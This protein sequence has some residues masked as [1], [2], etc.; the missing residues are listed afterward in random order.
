MASAEREPITGVWRR[1]DPPPLPPCKN[2]SDLYQFQERPLANVGGHVHPSPPRGDATGYVQLSFVHSTRTELDWT[3][4]RQLP[5]RIV[6]RYNWHSAGSLGWPLPVLKYQYIF[7]IKYTETI[8]SN[9]TRELLW[10]ENIK[11]LIAVYEKKYGVVYYNFRHTF[12]PYWKTRVENSVHSSSRAV[13]KALRSK[14]GAQ[15]VVWCLRVAVVSACKS[16]VLLF[17]FL[18]VSR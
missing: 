5:S 4:C 10:F 15:V 6:R 16:T 17:L 14:S 13:N 8:L 7:Q 18:V 3:A 11:M 9:R 2:S 12:V 1:S